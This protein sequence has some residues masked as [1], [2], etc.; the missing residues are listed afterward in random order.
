MKRGPWDC[1]WDATKE[2]SGCIQGSGPFAGSED[3][4]YLSI[5]TLKV[6]QQRLVTNFKTF[7]QN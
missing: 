6:T 1:V 4:L 3:C 2:R 7:Q 5:Y